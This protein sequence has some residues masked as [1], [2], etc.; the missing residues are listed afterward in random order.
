MIPDRNIINHLWDIYNLPES[1]RLHVTLV[2]RVALFLAG[3]LM[4][5]QITTVD[6]RLLE[7]AALLHDI[8]KNAPKLP[9]ERHPDA[10]IRILK[11]RGYYEVARVVST[12]PLHAICDTS[13]APHTWEEKLLF[14]A[15]K[16][17]K[18][19]IGTVDS[20]FA[21]WRAETDMPEEGRNMLEKT[22]PM[23]KKLE[24]E[25]LSL[26]TITAANV[27]KLA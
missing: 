22:Y 14:L 21:L 19:E 16:M 15:D 27:A 11:E 7:A 3:Q 5:Q 9:G 23:V 26:C 17:V 24:Q 13:I 8:D 10:C 25:I 6:V 2:A 12:H 20:R 1:K 18:F 4:K